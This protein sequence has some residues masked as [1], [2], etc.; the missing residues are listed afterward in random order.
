MLQK[1]NQ[2]SKGSS[3][4]GV[5]EKAPSTAEEF[6][7]IAKE[8]ERKIEGCKRK[9]KEREGV[10][11]QTVE[12]AADAFDEAESNPRVESV[13]ERCKEPIGKGNFHKTEHC[14]EVPKKRQSVSGT[15]G[16]KARS[17]LACDAWAELKQGSST[18][19]RQKMNAYKAFKACVPVTR[20]PNL[21]ITLVRGIPGTR[22]LHRRT[23]EALRLTKCNRTV[24][25]WN[26]P[27][28]KRLVV[29]ETEEMHNARKDKEA[30]HQARPPPLAVNHLQSIA[31]D[32]S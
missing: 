22:R 32:T 19:S 14:N 30:N 23:L 16:P 31:A 6:L 1:Y 17:V 21:Y 7:S 8:K 13:K 25:R 18:V 12:K 9:E 26:T 4:H 15:V 5:E 29:I 11:S 20:S 3:G 28:V 2:A 27:T 24:T 10:A